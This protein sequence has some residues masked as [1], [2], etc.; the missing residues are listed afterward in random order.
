MSKILIPTDFSVSSLS[1]LIDAI[2]NE[3]EQ[4]DIVL[5][6]GMSLP[7]SITELLFFS[8]QQT[9]N[10]LQSA[11]FLDALYSIQK[12]YQH[13]LNSVV[14]DFFHGLNKNAFHSYLEG[15]KIN[16]AYIPND[17]NSI[18]TNTKKGFNMISFIKKSTINVCEI[19]YPN[20]D[21]LK[22]VGLNT[23]IAR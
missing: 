10:E 9:L 11:E 23:L 7:T 8:K 6:Y 22:L 2:E 1:L 12:R 21:N 5:V 17:K 14:S 4:I 16:K 13:K 3:N 15:Q 20:G 18:L 19:T